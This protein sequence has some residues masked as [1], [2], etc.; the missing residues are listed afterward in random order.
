[1][2]PLRYFRS[3]SDPTDPLPP[4]SSNSHVCMYVCLYV[5]MVYPRI[6]C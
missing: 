4:V 3:P 1:M 6:G 5:S 2:P